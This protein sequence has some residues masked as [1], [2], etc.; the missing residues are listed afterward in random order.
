MNIW[1][2]KG[3]KVKVTEE[4]IKNGYDIDVADAQKY[5]KVN[6]TYTVNKTHIGNCNTG[7]ELIELPGI[8]FNSTQFEDITIQPEEL[9]QN[10][11]DYEKFQRK[12]F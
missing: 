6:Q 8:I 7:V 1:A 3:F 12:Y 9:N 10:H 11:P 5:L 2:L 4:S